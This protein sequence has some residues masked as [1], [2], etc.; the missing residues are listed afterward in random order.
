[1][2]PVPVI[3][4]EGDAV[5]T[6]DLNE[7]YEDLG[8]TALDDQDGNLS[9]L[10]ETNGTDEIDTSVPGEHTVTYDVRTSQEMLLYKSPAK[11][12]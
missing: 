5:V 2:T 3:T 8:A 7:V 4:L 11:S 9:F 6:V 10:I 1:M 12:S